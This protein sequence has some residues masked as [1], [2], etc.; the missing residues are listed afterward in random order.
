MPSI[1]LSSIPMEFCPSSLNCV[2]EKEVSILKKARNPN[3]LLMS[4]VT[5]AEAMNQLFGSAST[6]SDTTDA[7]I[8]D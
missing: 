7:I 3:I 1:Y 6:D 4:T 5:L 8:V 2:I